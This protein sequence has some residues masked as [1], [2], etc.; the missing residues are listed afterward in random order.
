MK[1]KIILLLATVAVICLSQFET[2]SRTKPARTKLED[3]FSDPPVDS[4][5]YGMVYVSHIALD[6]VSVLDPE[7]N[8][9]VRKIKSG[10][11]ACCVEL[12]S[13]LDHG[14]VADY[15]SND[16]IV[17]DTKTGKTIATVPAGDH[18]SHLVLT[19]DARYLLI[20][21]ESKD[22]LWFLDTRTN[23][24][25]KKLAEGTGILCRHEK[26]R[27]IYQSQI[28]TP[29][30][31]VI[32][33]ETQTI[34]KRINV[35]GRPLDLAYTPN[36]RYLYIANYDLNEVEQIDTES[37]SVVARIHGVNNARG[38]AVT[39]DGRFAYVT[40]VLSS[41]LTVID[42]ASAAIVKTIPVGTTPTSI[43]MR[44]DGRYA[45]VSCQG[46]ASVFVIDTKTQ[47]IT[48]SIV[49]DSNPITLQVR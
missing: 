1:A 18:P 20:G 33:P 30:V 22:G 23:E 25:V 6:N 4:I 7:N 14:Y 16:I 41:T 28:F 44:I 34:E 43:V 46:N 39:P 49:V 9:V 36:Q 11:G 21:H 47:E 38:I 10:M 48:Q 12:S 32:N 19:S 26:G 8:R 35:G 5:R 13:Q 29:F 45:Y 3:S 2:Y 15:T 40:N 42:L 24:V 37:D 27:K 31:Y 17:F